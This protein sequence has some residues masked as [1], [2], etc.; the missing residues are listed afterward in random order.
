M[1]SSWNR[2]QELD[3]KHGS[4]RINSETRERPRAFRA[5]GTRAPGWD[6][7]ALPALEQGQKQKAN[8]LKQYLQSQESLK[9]F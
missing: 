4:C 8:I 5:L 1:Q 6:M 7:W 9:A 3:A 2:E